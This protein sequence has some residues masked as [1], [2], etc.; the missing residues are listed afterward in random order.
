M[1]RR[2][3][4]RVIRAGHSS[5]SR[6]SVGQSVG[7]G[8]RPRIGASAREASFPNRACCLR[9]HGPDRRRSGQDGH[10]CRDHYLRRRVEDCVRIRSDCGAVDPRGVVCRVARGVERRSGFSCFR[11]R[12]GLV[13]ARLGGLD[14]WSCGLS[15]CWRC[16]GT[17]ARRS[18]GAA[19]GRSSVPSLGTGCSRAVRRCRSS[20]S[21]AGSSI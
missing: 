7:D 10:I 20:R 18:G 4:V 16:S 2:R 14:E 11:G 21:P 8:G 3:N 17:A 12:P 5:R 13:R 9:S 15:E 1:L 19:R 6:S